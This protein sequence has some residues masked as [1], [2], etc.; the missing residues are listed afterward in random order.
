MRIDKL[1]ILIKLELN[2][3]INLNQNKKKFLSGI[4]LTIFLGLILLFYSIL[5]TFMSISRFKEIMI[6]GF[7]AATFLLIFI[8]GIIFSNNSLFTKVEYERLFP[9]PI[10]S[11]EIIFSKIVGIY[12]SS[13]FYVI[14]VLL[15]PVMLISFSDNKLFLPMAFLVLIFFPLIPIA[16]SFVVTLFLGSFFKNR[17]L[18]ILGSFAT[19]ILIIL[20]Y[21]VFNFSRK[22]LAPKLTIIL[23][24]ILFKFYPIKFF[25]SIILNG[26]FLGSVVFMIISTIIFLGISKLMSK[27]YF[28]IYFNDKSTDRKFFSKSSSLDNSSKPTTVFRKEF[29]LYLTYPTYVINTIFA[30]ITLLLF[31]ILPLF[32]SDVLNNITDFNLESIISKHLIIILCAFAA[33]GNT[34]YCSLSIEGKTYYLLQTLPL[35][36]LD[37]FKEKIKLALSLILIPLL[38]SSILLGI[39]YNI[40][41]FNIIVLILAAM[42]FSL[43]ANLIGIIYD[44]NTLNINWVN[45]QEIVKQRF[46]M[47]IVQLIVAVVIYLLY[48]ISEVIIKNNDT[49]AWILIFIIISLLNLIMIRYLNKKDLRIKN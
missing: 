1:K 37:I 7:G 18:K 49:F 26:K 31:G 16:L 25:N 21:V 35:K 41:P 11:L 14:T 2:R 36:P 17:F 32:S 22:T 20:F 10:T 48:L 15:F 33:V 27:N 30:P 39:R 9:L 8:N 44:L 40:K 6:G 19:T 38:V 47:L 34:T 4:A 24:D 13:L 28:D 29:S 45:P 46:S 3:I 23:F 5:I 42:S 43:F 12:I